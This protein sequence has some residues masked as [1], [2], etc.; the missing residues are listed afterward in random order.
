MEGLTCAA[1]PSNMESS[2]ERE[3]GNKMEFMLIWDWV[4]EDDGWT[5]QQLVDYFRTKEELL[6]AYHQALGDHASMVA[7]GRLILSP[8]IKYSWADLEQLF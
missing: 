1:A 8:A 4:D 3:K 7:I 2:K 5:Y 6:E